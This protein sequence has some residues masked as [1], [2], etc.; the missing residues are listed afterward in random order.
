MKALV[1]YIAEEDYARYQ[2]LVAIATQ[3]KAEAPKERKPREPLTHEQKIARQERAVKAA[4][5][6]LAKLLALQEAGQTAE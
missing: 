3:R 1:D 2:E 5:E 6:K 4:E